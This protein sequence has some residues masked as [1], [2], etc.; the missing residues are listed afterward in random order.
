MLGTGAVKAVAV[1]IDGDLGHYR[2]AG[3]HFASGQYA[4]VQLFQ[5]AE[6]LKNDQVH[7]FFIQGGDLLAEGLA[8]LRQGDFA[9]RLNSNAERPNRSCDQS[10]E[11]LG[12]LA[13]Q[14]GAAPIDFCQPVDTTVLRQTKRI[15]A[16]G[17]CFYDVGASLQVF[18]VN[19]PDEVR[20]RQVQFVIT[21]VN[22]DS[23]GQQQ[24]AHG[25]VAKD[26][27]FLQS[28]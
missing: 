4:L 21:A 28:S 17:V 7:T 27:P 5:I 6:G 26:S 25:A 15:C 19:S 13:G 24:R 22:E 9:Q 10:I 2:K 18:Q 20:L 8:S 11:A 14:T 12:G 1:F 16:K 3:V 23:L